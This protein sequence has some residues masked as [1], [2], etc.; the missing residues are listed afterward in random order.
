MKHLSFQLNIREGISGN[1]LTLLKSA[2]CNRLEEF[3][4]ISSDKFRSFVLSVI[5]EHTVPHNDF[6]SLF[7]IVNQYATLSHIERLFSI[8]MIGDQLTL[9]RRGTKKV[10]YCSPP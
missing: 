2:I 1:T 10:Q 6:C 4:F 9:F 3:T 5:T 7:P 8:L